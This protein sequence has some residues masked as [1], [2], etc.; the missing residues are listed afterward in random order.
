MIFLRNVNIQSF[1]DDGSAGNIQ[2][3]YNGHH[4][5]PALLSGAKY[6]AVGDKNTPTIPTLD[7]YIADAIAKQAPLRRLRPDLH[8]ADDRAGPRP[9][10]VQD[11]PACSGCTWT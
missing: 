8:A 6:Q 4:A 1:N 7:H 5:G 3:G 2:G 11:A 10:E 9:R